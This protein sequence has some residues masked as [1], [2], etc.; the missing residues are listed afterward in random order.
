M[1]QA[2]NIL[3]RVVARHGIDA[4]LTAAGDTYTSVAD[5]TGSLKVLHRKYEASPDEKPTG[6]ISDREKFVITA[7][8]LAKTSFTTI[9]PYYRLTIDGFIYTIKKA[10]PSYAYGERVRWDIEAAGQQ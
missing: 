4:T 6:L 7:A 8:E 3:A 9:K 5:T 10:T 2:A 1:N